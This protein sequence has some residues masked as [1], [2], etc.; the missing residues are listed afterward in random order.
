MRIAWGM[1]VEQQL[2]LKSISVPHSGPANV[3]Y[4]NWGVAKNT[5]IPESMLSK[6]HCL[7]NDHIVFK[8]IAA[9]IV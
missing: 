9:G 1:I 2:K 6:K 5:R 7:I 8:P 4:N 3:Y